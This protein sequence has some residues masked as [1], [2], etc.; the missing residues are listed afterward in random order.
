MTVLRTTTFRTFHQ[1]GIVT[2][3]LRQD[4]DRF[5]VRCQPRGYPVI[6][7]YDTACTSL[8][9]AEAVYAEKFSI[10]MVGHA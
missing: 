3:S 10:G 7:K 9:D 8:A 1:G 4:A 5:L 2:L 6:P